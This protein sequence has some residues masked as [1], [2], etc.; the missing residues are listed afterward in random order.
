MKQECR[1]S[2]EIIFCITFLGIAVLPSTAH[3]ALIDCVYGGGTNNWSNTTAWNGGA[4]SA[5]F[6]NNDAT[7]T[8]N[9]TVGSGT[10]TLDQNIT[11]EAFTF[12]GGA[13]TGANDLTINNALAWTGGGMSGTGVTRAEG[14]MVISGAA[15]KSIGGNYEVV[16]A[17]GQTADWSEGHIEWGGSPSAAPSLTN[18]G[19]FNVTGAS[20]SFQQG[21]FSTAIG[22]FDNS[23][24]FNV[25]LSDAGQTLTVQQTT[26]NN[27]GTVDV[28][29]GVLALQTDAS[30][31]GQW[32][33]DGGKLQLDPG[34]D[35]TTTGP[36]A[37]VNGGELELNNGASMTGSGLTLDPTATLDMIGNST[38]SLSGDLSFAMTNEAQ[39]FFDDA[40]T[41]E[42]AGGVGAVVGN[43]A[44]WSSLEIG[45]FDIGTDPLNHVGDP[46]GF[47]NNFDLAELVIGA[48]AHVFL[49]DIWDNGNR[50]GTFG[51]EEALYVDTLMFADAS[52]LLNLNG[53]HI[54]YK[55]LIGN[56]DQI[57]NQTVVPV[58]A[59]VWLFGSGLIGLIGVAR[60]K[61]A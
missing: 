41:L 49:S 58:P 48:D 34:A 19:T 23:G 12:T 46:S 22:T 37:V 1:G 54:Y 5:F 26:F 51:V 7:N 13:V 44:A 27:S 17:A 38:L 11:I 8:F 60:R 29:N 25:N 45:G 40:S 31:T 57:I 3:A 55:N 56:T 50:N 43:W 9:A 52:A 30:G 4:C 15:A 18:E 36:I 10:V 39:W 35:V 20:R 61:T 28:Q 6:P 24:D 14:G 53:L 59:A 21:G 47:S 2:R 42:M 33:A 32:Q 16:N